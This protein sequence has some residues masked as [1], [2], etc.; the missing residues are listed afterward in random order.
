[1]YHAAIFMFK[2]SVGT[3]D[4]QHYWD[5]SYDFDDK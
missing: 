5:Q 3:S 4:F 1:M 2:S